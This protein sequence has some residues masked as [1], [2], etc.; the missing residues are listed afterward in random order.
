MGTLAEEANLWMIVNSHGGNSM[1]YYQ[2]RRIS[3][4]RSLSSKEHQ[5][6]LLVIRGDLTD[7]SSLSAGMEFLVF[8][9]LWQGIIG[10]GLGAQSYAGAV[11]NR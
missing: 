3:L 10:L 2:I 1:R 9:L 4:Q 7:R 8:A 11:Y 5:V 6:Y